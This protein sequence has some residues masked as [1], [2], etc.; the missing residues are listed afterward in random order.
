MSRHTYL[1]KSQDKNLCVN[2]PCSP[3]TRHTHTHWNQRFS[4][5]SISLNI[6]LSFLPFLS[7]NRSLAR[8]WARKSSE[9]LPCLLSS[10]HSRSPPYLHHYSPP[11]TTFNDLM[12]VSLPPFLLGHHGSKPPPPPQHLP[13]SPI[14][15]DH[16]PHFLFTHS[17]LPFYHF[18]LLNTYNNNAPWILS[19]K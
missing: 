8:K 11:S 9:D 18:L 13:I 1:L 6:H 14:K 12:V 10:K 15:G 3:K 2:L 5:M 17:I 4:L 16:F 19:S 7:P